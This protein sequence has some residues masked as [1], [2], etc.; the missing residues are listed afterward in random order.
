[1]TDPTAEPH[2]GPR[3]ACFI[4]P[5]GFGHATRSAAVMEALR[6]R[7]SDVEFDIFTT[8]PI[9]IFDESITAPFAYH[10]V[11]TDIGVVQ[12][13][14]F[15]GDLA[16]TIKHLDAFLPFDPVFIRH[17]A[18]TLQ[19]RQCRLI[20]CDIAPLGIAV[21]RRAGIPSVLIEN[22]TW[23]WIYRRLPAAD[24]LE[25]HA[26]YLERMFNAADHHIQTEPV[27][28]PQAAA[29]TVAPVSRSARLAPEDVRKRL[30]VSATEKLVLITTGG[31]PSQVGYTGA[32]KAHRDVAFVVPGGSRTATVEENLILL[33]PR[34]GFYHPDLVNASDLVVGKVGYSTVA[35]AYN[36]GVPMAYIARADYPEVTSLVDF[37]CRHLPQ[38]AVEE[39]AFIDG[40]WLQ[41]LPEL[42]ALPRAP[43]AGVNGAREA[44][45][46]I[47]DLLQ[48]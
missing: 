42:L 41:R 48:S 28:R 8:V 36:A 13:S 16:Q 37:I 21:G 4:S 47:V 23:D 26:R 24:V 12:T 25:S 45:D 6:E 43:S 11:Q 20:L 40:R 35:E 18:D 34:S 33:P 9:W 3:I 7:I 32:L 29:R 44:A 30:Q 27:C 1:M 2:V 15:H 38:A 10:A 14:P 39:A 31:I 17:L 22:F 19:D 5:H 46:I